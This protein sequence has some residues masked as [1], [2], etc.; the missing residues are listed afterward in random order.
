[1]GKNLRMKKF[2]FFSDI[3]F[4]FCI[5]GIFSLVFFRSLKIGV[6]GAFL[7]A[8]VCGGLIALS[9]GAILRMRRNNLYLKKTDETQKRKLLLHLALL[10]DEG[11]TE[12]LKSA[13]STE[14]EPLKRFGRLRVF[15]KT[16]FFFLKFSPSPLS[17]DEIPSL[18]RLKT[19][20][21][22]ILLCAEIEPAALELCRRL[23]IQ[24]KTG[25]WVYQTLKT[26]GTLPQAYLGDS[27]RP[28]KKRVTLWF[29]RK[30]AKRFLVGG[31]LLLLLSRLTPYYSY[32]LLIGVLLLLTSVLVRV[33][34]YE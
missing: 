23:D 6:G 32:Y 25:E 12:F 26:L 7:L 4:A 27:P 14:D 19:G 8:L 13:L 16:E 21:K 30:N 5:G 24:V 33:F 10:S 11:K 15:N 28:P 18:A 9:F 34:G 2:A 31:S 3:L 17:A 22:K 29:S 20:K 1:M